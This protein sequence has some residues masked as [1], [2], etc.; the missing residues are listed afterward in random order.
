MRRDT[1][2][3]AAPG[4]A[5]AAW[6]TCGCVRGPRQAGSTISRA[7]R[8]S[9]IAEVHQPNRFFR[10]ASAGAGDS[11]DAQAQRRAG[12]LANSGRQRER[13]LGAHRAFRLRSAQPALRPCSSSARC[14]SDHS[15]HEIRRAA[16]ACSSTVR[17]AIRRCSFRRRQWSRD[18]RSA[19]AQRFARAI[20]PCVEKRYSPSASDMRLDDFVE[21][22]FGFGWIVRPHARMKLNAGWRR[23]NRGVRIGILARRAA[24]RAARHRIRKFP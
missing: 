2:N 5:R 15:A 10:R 23:E 18:F 20:R 6:K 3:T 1:E 17:P 22:V 9:A 24:R 14:C 7:P 21:H 8:S 11:S 13:D 16:S 4:P 19:D 12:A